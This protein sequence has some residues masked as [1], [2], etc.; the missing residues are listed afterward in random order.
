MDSEPDRRLRDRFRLS[1]RAVL[2]GAAGGSL[3]AGA[4]ATLGSLDPTANSALSA[5]SQPRKRLQSMTTW[6]PDPTFY[7]SARMA[8]AAPPEELAYVVRVNPND[9]DR[10]DGIVVIDTSPTSTTYGSVVG[11]VEMGYAGTSCIIS[12]GMP[13]ARCFVR[14]R[15]IRMSSGA[16]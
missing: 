11:E 1:R 14:V 13:V 9:D 6:R 8:M 5:D 3:L 15:R 12:A 7:P 2:E 10:P 16:T 4:A